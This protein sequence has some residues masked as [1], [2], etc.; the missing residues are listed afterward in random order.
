MKGPT[1]N[2]GDAYLLATTAIWG[3]NFPIAKSV[4]DVLDPFAFA[5]M[6]WIVAAVAL[7]V[8]VLLRTRDLLVP[9][10]DFLIMA[11]LGSFGVAV[12]QTVWTNGLALT[13][14]AK[15]SILVSTTPI[16]AALGGVLIGRAP[17]LRAWAGAALGFGG[18]FLLVNN[19]LSE[20]TVGGGS[21]KGDLM[22]LAVAALWAVYSAGAAPLIARHGALKT[23]FWIIIVGSLCLALFTAPE[24]AATDWRAVGFGTWSELLYTA[25][26]SAA[27]GFVWWYEGIR[28]LG[29]VRAM[30]YSYLI[31]VFGIAA[32]AA[33]LGDVMSG[34][35]M[36]GAALALAGVAL[37][38]T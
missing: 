29:P 6:R 3:L 7:V 9:W 34:V 1:F 28:Y 16:F 4:L 21:L 36:L 38:R 25:I 35:Q 17:S 30:L 5:G 37:A 13:T 15:G 33:M 2:R 26:F 14:A 10:R 23:T 31:P 27:L 11:A 18:V 32:S 22:M 8:V 12:F 20:I 24:M 19:S